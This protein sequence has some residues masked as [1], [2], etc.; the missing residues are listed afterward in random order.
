M[1]KIV[2]AVTSAQMRAF[3]RYPLELYKDCDYYVPCFTSDEKNIKNPKK[4]YAAEGCEVK[5]F[6]A[7]KNGRIVGRIAGVIVSESNRKFGEKKIRF[8]R[9]DFN[10]DED[11]AEAL[12]SKV[13]EF[14]KERGMTVIHGPW[15]FNDTDREGMLTS[16]FD[17]PATYATNYNYEYY[18]DVVR[19]LGFKKES[20]WVEFAIYPGT[21][22]PKIYKAADFVQKRYG[23]VELNDKYPIKR[24][25]REYGDL[26]F[27]C[28]NEAYKDLDCYVELK[29]KVKQN[30][31]TQF[32]TVINQ[33]YFSCILDPKTGKIAAFGVVIPAIGKIIK[34]HNGNLLASAIPLLKA[35]KKPDALELTLIG[36]APEY[37]NSGVNAMIITRIHRNI[38]KN[39]IKNV[40][41]NP[42][43]TTNAGILTQW[44]WVEHEEIKRRATFEKEISQ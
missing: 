14:G 18:A 23:F 24:I 17:R 12:L 41:C 39:G 5:C 27:D 7:E 8:S 25:I 4:N 42:M 36:V 19:K 11:V 32:A 9:F 2:E 21:L 30:V 10:G 28:Y 20:E 34:K 37:R 44:K 35:K 40:V 38:M 31:I 16:G 43:L 26:F 1:V 13:A 15:G 6:L 22:D 3:A 29:G 33:D